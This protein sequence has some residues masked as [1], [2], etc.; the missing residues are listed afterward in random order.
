MLQYQ[1]R[2]NMEMDNSSGI[3]IAGYLR[4]KEKKQEEITEQLAVSPQESGNWVMDVLML[5]MYNCKKWL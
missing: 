5:Q 2:E 4:R 1:R 3:R